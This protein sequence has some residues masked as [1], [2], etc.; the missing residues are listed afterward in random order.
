MEI[1]IFEVL[2]YKQAVQPS[3]SSPRE[4]ACFDRKEQEKENVS[5]KQRRQSRHW[6]A[7]NAGRSD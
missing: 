1:R 2:L 7:D 3:K 5:S 6:E 4:G